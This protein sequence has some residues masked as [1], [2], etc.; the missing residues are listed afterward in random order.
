MREE[1][2][3]K[4]QNTFPKFFCNHYALP[5]TSD[6]WFVILWEMCNKIKALNPSDNF[7]LTQIKEK[8]GTLRVYSYC[9]TD[10]IQDVILDA[11]IKSSTT[12]EECGQPG[13]LRNGS[14]LRTLCDLHKK[15]Y[16]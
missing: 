15:E 1:L 4:L 11:E 7:E 12:C 13:K 6:G 5:T 9:S 16:K 2:I 10:I 3:N 14:W 8:F